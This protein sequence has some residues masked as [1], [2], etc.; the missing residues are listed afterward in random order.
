MAMP[1]AQKAVVGAVQ[2]AEIGQASGAF[3]MLRMFGG[4]LGTTITVAVFAG[5]GSYASVETFSTGFAA[6]MGAVTVLAFVGM[7]FALGIPGRRP[8]VVAESL[9]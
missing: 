7:L 3:M 5:F 8:T 6:G 9:L 1:A 4:V 2:P